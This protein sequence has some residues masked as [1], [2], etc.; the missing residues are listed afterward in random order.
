M[1]LLYDAV[2]DVN[3][4]ATNAF[5]N[6]K[7][8][9]DRLHEGTKYLYDLAEGNRQQSEAEIEKKLLEMADIQQAFTSEVGA[10]IATHTKGKE[11]RSRAKDLQ[12]K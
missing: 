1:V 3:I 11:S 8:S 2:A 9:Y 4:R 6:V 5:Q 10:M 7:A 12:A